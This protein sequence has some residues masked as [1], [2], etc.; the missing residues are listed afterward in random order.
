MK[1]DPYIIEAIRAGDNS[2]ALSLLYDSTLKKVRSYIIKNNGNKE[3]ADDIFQEAIVIFFLKVKDRS[4]DETQSIEGFI[5]AISR[6]LWINR[7]KRIASHKKFELYLQQNEQYEDNDQLSE[8]V[9]REKA[10]AMEQVFALLEE[11]CRIILKYAIYDQLSMKEIS[12]KMGHKNDK[13][14]KAQHYRCKQYLAKLVKENK[15][16]MEVLGN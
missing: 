1:K 12:V 15:S 4:F 11:K 7:V 5:F 8:L 16:I 9:D 14:S 13:V 6:N 3:E 2:A 10:D